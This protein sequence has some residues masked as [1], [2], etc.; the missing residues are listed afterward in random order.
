MVV[1]SRSEDI[2]EVKRIFKTKYSETLK[3]LGQLDGKTLVE[4]AKYVGARLAKGTNDEFGIDLKMNQIRKFLDALRRIEKDIELTRLDWD[5]IRY[6][7]ILL[8]PKLAYSAGR[9]DAVKPLMVV[10]EPAINAA[11]KDPELNFKKLLHFM[12]AIVAYHSF[13]GG[14][15]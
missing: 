9:V 4:I 5:E 3:N 10:L 2:A 8:Q 6:K 1:K 15:N 13:Y 11:S 7:L 14:K 12:E